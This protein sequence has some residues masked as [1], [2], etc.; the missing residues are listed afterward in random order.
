[1]DGGNAQ[2]QTIEEQ[3]SIS[4]KGVKKKTKQENLPVVKRGRGRPMFVPTDL[5]RQRVEELAGCGVP[6]HMIASLIR[7]GISVD[8]LRA[9]MGHELIRGRAKAAEG[10]GKTL[11]S[12]AMAGDAAAMIWYT[13]AQMR[14]S[15][16]PQEI[17]IQSDTR[18]SIQSA[19]T[20][21][22]SRIIEG[23]AR[24]LPEEGQE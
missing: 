20:A 14:W 9:R 16:A 7:D 8:A 19:L 18:I 23:D 12:R 10:V 6:E 11:Y 3:V 15:A 17:R 21:A 2:V 1:M 24:E 5:E 13:K 4:G 22:D